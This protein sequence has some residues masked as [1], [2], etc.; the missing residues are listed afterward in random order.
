MLREA[1]DNGEKFDLYDW[2][3]RESNP[4]I[5]FTLVDVAPFEFYECHHEL[6]RDYGVNGAKRKTAVG[7]RLKSLSTIVPEILYCSASDQD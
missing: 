5:D 6:H 1:I 7:P 2:M 3:L 4:H